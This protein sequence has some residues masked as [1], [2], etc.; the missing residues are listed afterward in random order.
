MVVT[1]EKKFTKNSNSLEE[2]IYNITNQTKQELK[3]LVNWT[4]NS[5]LYIWKKWRREREAKKTN[6]EAKKENKQENREVKNLNNDVSIDKLTPWDKITLEQENI[7]KQSLQSRKSPITFEMIR[8]SSIAHGVPVELLLS[9]MQNDSQLWTAGKGARTHNPWNVWNTDNWGTKDFWTWEKWV[10]AC[11]ENIKSRIDAY[12]NT[13]WWIPIIWE[14]LTWISRTWKKFFWIYMS[15]P[16]WP[17]R[18]L[19]IV[20]WWIKK[21]TQSS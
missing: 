7:I 13:I 16:K 1:F 14:L 9:V 20:K 15:D 6:K 8:D 3:D 19:N 4:E 17:S 2:E 11:A 18:V 12:I 10:D 5:T 21:L